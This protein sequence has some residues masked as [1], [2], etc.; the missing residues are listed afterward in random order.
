MCGVC[1]YE[2]IVSGQGGGV[3]GGLGGLLWDPTRGEG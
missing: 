3:G 2:C 1:L